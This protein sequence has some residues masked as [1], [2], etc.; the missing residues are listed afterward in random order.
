[1]P[2]IGV[3]Q[4]VLIDSILL[5]AGYSKDC[6]FGKVSLVENG[7]DRHVNWFLSHVWPV[8]YQNVKHAC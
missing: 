3:I 7:G 1:M 6:H 5:L 8:T 2:P 4:F